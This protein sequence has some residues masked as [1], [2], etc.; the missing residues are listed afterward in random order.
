[1]ADLFDYSEPARVLSP[2][3]N[4]CVLDPDTGWCIGCGR[5][6]DEIGEWPDA[7]DARRQAILDVLPGRMDRLTKS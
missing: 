1:V 2:C 3:T 4:V 6:C 7:G 5:S